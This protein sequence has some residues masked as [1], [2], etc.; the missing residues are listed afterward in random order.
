[1]SKTVLNVTGLS[2][3]L[4]VLHAQKAMK[5]LPPGAVVEIQATD[6]AVVQDI[7]AYC[8][9]SGSALISQREEGGVFTVEIRKGG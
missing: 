8:R 7:D 6:P 4:P 3:P 1:M 2:C 9:S 5:G